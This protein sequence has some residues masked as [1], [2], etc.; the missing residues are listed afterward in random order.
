MGESEPAAQ[1]RRR[2]DGSPPRNVDAANR[3]TWAGVPCRSNVGTAGTDPVQRPPRGNGHIRQHHAGQRARQVH[4]LPPHN[5]H[6]MIGLQHKPDLA[7]A[8]RGPRGIQDSGARA[9]DPHRQ[10]PPR[11]SQPRPVPTQHARGAAASEART[12]A[13]GSVRMRP[14]VSRPVTPAARRSS[15]AHGASL[16]RVLLFSGARY[17]S[18][19]EPHT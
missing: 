17:G 2:Q 3:S 16:E 12:E 19:T 15:T 8:A 9:A 14:D 6:G 4:R 13:I 7:A 18:G 1:H 10:T 5:A 11:T